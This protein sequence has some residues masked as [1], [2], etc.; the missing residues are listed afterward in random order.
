MSL[1]GSQQNTLHNPTL[2]GVDYGKKDAAPIFVIPLKEGVD[3][4][5]QN[6]N[7]GRHKINIGNKL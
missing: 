3:P 1:T 6:Q 4:W 5:I 7:Q 2:I